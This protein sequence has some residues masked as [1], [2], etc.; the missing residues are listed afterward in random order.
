MS[1]AQ[2]TLGLL[3][4]CCLSISILVFGMTMTLVRSLKG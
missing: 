1:P 2:L 4:T 3:V